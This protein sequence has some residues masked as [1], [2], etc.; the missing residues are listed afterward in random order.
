MFQPAAPRPPAI[1]VLEAD[2]YQQK[3]RLALSDG[4]GMFHVLLH[5]ISEILAVA[6]PWFFPA[7]QTLLGPMQ[8]HI[9][10]INQ[11]IAGINHHLSVID[12]RLDSLSD[13]AIETSIL[14]AQVL[15]FSD[16]PPLTPVN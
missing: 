15:K 9:N 4:Q 2:S 10:R 14:A 11:E 7:M 8:E 1:A 12:G 6:P 13:Y 5:D 3:I 16:L